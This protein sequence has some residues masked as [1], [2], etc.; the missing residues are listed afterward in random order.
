M[1]EGVPWSKVIGITIG[2]LIVGGVVGFGIGSNTSTPNGGTHAASSSSSNSDSYS[3][4]ITTTTAPAIPPSAADFQ[5]DVVVTEQ[6]CFGSAGCNYELNINPRYVGLG[7]LTGKWMVVYQINGGEEPQTGNFTL[8]GDNVR[9]DAEK[10]IEGSAGAV[11]TAQVTQVV[12]Q[13]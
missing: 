7:P 9:W 10:T 11:F 4:P 6:K 12:K 2:A 1:S 8:D 13:Y 5:V 3:P